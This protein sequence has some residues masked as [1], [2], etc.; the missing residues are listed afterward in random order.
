[1]KRIQGENPNLKDLCLPFT[2]FCK[3]NKIETVM[4]I[5]IGP[6]TSFGYGYFDEMPAA[7]VLKYFDVETTLEF[8]AMRLWT[9]KE[10]TEYIWANLNEAIKHPAILKIE[11]VKVVRK[12]GKIH[13]TVK[14]EKGERTEVYDKLI[15]TTPLDLFAQIA[16]ADEEEKDLFFKIV[17]EKYI[18]MACRPLKGQNPPS[19][20]TSSTT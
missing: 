19:T 13:V 2:Q 14:D 3:L 5:W 9:W 11:V 7:Y 1:M 17:H 8:I 6:F 20:P 12:N 4:R 10:G 18:S 15:V 16:D